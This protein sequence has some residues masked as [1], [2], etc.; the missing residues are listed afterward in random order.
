MPIT[1]L[2]I[3]ILNIKTKT[4]RDYNEVTH[5]E[6]LLLYI[7]CAIIS[8]LLLNARICNKTGTGVMNYAQNK[9]KQLQ[10]VM[11]TCSK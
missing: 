5:V 1:C 10:T 4:P 11:S 7:Y 8:N 6:F 3:K 9:C 2:Y